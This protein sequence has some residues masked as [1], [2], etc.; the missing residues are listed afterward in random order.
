MYVYIYIIYVCKYI[1]IY[2]SLYVNIYVYIY[3]YIHIYTYIMEVSKQF[4]CR[5]S[6]DIKFLKSGGSSSHHGRFNTS[7]GPMSSIVEKGVAL[8]LRKP[9]HIS[10]RIGSLNSPNHWLGPKFV[11]VIGPLCCHRRSKSPLGQV[12]A[13]VKMVPRF[14]EPMSILG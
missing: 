5:Y 10:Q 8:W 6:I 3:M 14:M 9:P 4:G 12:T 1:Y 13:L 2:I 11:L 7:R